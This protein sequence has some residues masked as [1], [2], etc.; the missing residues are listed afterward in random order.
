MKNKVLVLGSI[1]TIILA[2]LW[3]LEKITEPSFALG[4]GIITLIGYIL[5]P[6]DSNKN[7][8]TVNKQNHS[9][10][11]DNVLGNKTINN[12]YTITQQEKE[13]EKGNSKIS[14]F[15]ATEIQKAVDDGPVFQKEEI[16]KN[17]QAIRIKWRVNLNSFHPKL[18]SIY[19]LMTRYEGSYPWVLFDVDLN[20]YPT[21][22]VAKEGKRLIVTGK[23][24]NYKNGQFN[25]DLEDLQET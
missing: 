11:G 14:D 22:K 19:K 23:I 1:A 12:H 5:A 18:G 20:K 8:K 9:G 3:Y 17:Y 21:L 6:E 25:I 10:L 4:A 13:R 16:A 15:S 2:L 7:A 24:L